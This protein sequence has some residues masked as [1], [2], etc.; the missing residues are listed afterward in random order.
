MRKANMKIR[1]QRGASITFAL[2]LFLVCAMASA[3][4]IVSATAAGGR[5]AQIAE[6]DQRYYA[7]NSAA[8]MLK[9][10]FDGQTVEL[11]TESTKTKT[12]P[13]NEYGIEISTVTPTETIK[14]TT[15]LK[16][17][18]GNDLYTEVAESEDGDTDRNP[19]FKIESNVPSPLVGAACYIAG[20]KTVG[21]VGTTIPTTGDYSVLKTLTAGG[22]SDL[23]VNIKEVIASAEKEN[24]TLYI[25]IWKNKKKKDG[26]DDP[27]LAYAVRLAF[28][29]D[30]QKVENEHTDNGPVVKTGTDTYTK[31][32]VY[33]KKTTT[34]FVWEL[35]SINKS[36][37]PSTT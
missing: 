1:S 8:N 18:A 22:V 17:K 15:W 32:S 24:N 6:T 20:V 23:T 2:L 11:I 33:T 16:D 27:N 9:E 34:T 10:V 13:C 12:V 29:A 30:K 5:L 35:V 4:A 37:K 28:V 31:T 21:T 25:Y 36:G 14:T 26:T 3:V 7:V 19:G